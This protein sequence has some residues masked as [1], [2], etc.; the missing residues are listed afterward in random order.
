MSVLHLTFVVGPG[1]RGSWRLLDKVSHGELEPSWNKITMFSQY[2]LVD[3]ASKL[4]SQDPPTIADSRTPAC[5]AL[6]NVQLSAVR[7][8]MFIQI[9][10]KRRTSHGY[11]G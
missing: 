5:D 9:P 10:A 6:I 11:L 3:Q 2:A 4:F 1:S 7:L 8:G